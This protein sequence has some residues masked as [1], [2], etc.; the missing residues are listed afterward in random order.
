T[1]LASWR[2][3]DPYLPG[4]S[5]FGLPHAIGLP[6]PLGEP[7]LWL[8]IATIAALA[9]ACHIAAPCAAQ[10][11]KRCHHQ[12]LLRTS[13][14]ISCPV[15]ALP[16]TLGVTDP[17]VIALMCLSLAW[18]A[19][20]ARSRL[21][22]G[23]AIGVGCAMKATAWPALPVVAALVAFRDGW[24]AATRFAS[25]SL[26]SCLVLI[27]VTAPALLDR[28]RAL[29]QNIVAYPLGMSRR[30]TQAAS[31]LPGH[32]IASTGSLGHLVAIALLAGAALV[33][34]ASLVLRPPRDVRQATV[35]L[36]VSLAVVFL[37]APDARFGY[38]AYPLGILCWLMLTVDSPRVGTERPPLDGRILWRWR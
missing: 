21:L 25:A 12:T 35:R 34:G 17:P 26:G 8:A 5:L 37:L 22:A 14:L 11:G 3:Y 18:A 31:P 4:M 28:P 32:L 23:A 16:M 13:L 7:R 30:P 36:A 29:W 10:G 38:F 9:A 33:V 2:S 20:S 19:R 24:R 6:G 27:A 15:F 1:Q